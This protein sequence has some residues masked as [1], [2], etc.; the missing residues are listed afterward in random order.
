MQAYNE[1]TSFAVN[2]FN[3]VFDFTNDTFKLALTNTLPVA[4]QTTFNLTDHP[5]PVAANGYTAG[6]A[7][8]TI[9]V[10]NNA[11]VAEISGDKVTF[12]ATS[13]GIGPFRYAILYND[14]AVTPSKAP[15]C[16]WDYGESITLK[17]AETYVAKFND[18]DTGLIVT[19]G[20]QA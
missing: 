5:A 18:A 16:W 8:V 19:L 4:S 6:G 7:T 12:T 3:G 1:F 13:G 15:V 20:K 11:G 9:S 14:S 2:S 17:E 10:V